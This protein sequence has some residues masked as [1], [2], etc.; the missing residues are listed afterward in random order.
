MSN[1]NKVHDKLDKIFQELISMNI[2]MT[3]V[4]GR[5][6][7]YNSELEFHI[8]RTNQIEDELAPVVKHV[9]QVKGAG[10]LVLW[11]SLVATIVGG[12]SW[13]WSK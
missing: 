13:I 6:D 8:A 12:I 7:K 9:E 5:L 1:D 2:H 10:K 4:D 3:K 11:L